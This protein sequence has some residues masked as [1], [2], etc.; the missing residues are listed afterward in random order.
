MYDLLL[1]SLK[2]GASLAAFFLFF[3]LLLSRETF[4]RLNRMLVLGAVVLSFV[5][6]LCVVTVYRELP[7]QPVLPAVPVLD[8]MPAAV[9]AEE[10]AGFAWETLAGALFA[11]G[12]VAA[13]LRTLC[14]LACVL[15]LVRRGR[16][17]RLEG[18]SVLVHS[19]RTGVPFSWWRYIVIPDEDLAHSGRE[20]L[21]H[22][23][24]HL[25]LRHSADLLLMDLAGCLQWFNP[26]FWLLRRELRA[27]HEYEADREVLRSG[28]DPKAYQ[29]LLV[30]KAAGPG[31][32]SVAN[33]FNH[34]KLK[35]RIDMMLRR[36]SSR[37]AGAKALLALPLAALAVGAFAETSYVVPQIEPAAGDTLALSKTEITLRG[38]P[39]EPLV[40][41]DRRVLASARALDSLDAAKIASIT[42]LRDSTA[43]L[44][45]GTQARN[46]VVIV[47]TKPDS[48][49]FRKPEFRGEIGL[50]AFRIDSS[51]QNRSSQIDLRLERD[52]LQTG[53]VQTDNARRVHI[54]QRGTK[55]NPLFLV[56]GVEVSDLKDL[57]PQQIESMEVIKKMTDEVRERGY[58]GVVRITTRRGSDF[59][60]P[61]PE[62]IE[63]EVVRSTQE[64]LRSAQ[65][66]IDAA[67]KVLESA[68]E[69]IP[70]KQWEQA[71]RDLKKAQK[72]LDQT[73][74]QLAEARRKRAEAARSEGRIVWGGEGVATEQEKTV[75]E[76]D[77][78]QGV[79]IYRGEVTLLGA[80]D[81]GLILLNG[82]RATKADV[83][84]IAPKK[85]RS[86]A[87]YS[88][89]EALRKFGEE[90]RD[91]V[92]VI[93]T[94]K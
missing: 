19:A 17:E 14:S 73:R 40:V 68:R 85:I 55:G 27:I 29:M 52:T 32:Y 76:R 47:T 88:G 36:K 12:A 54:R 92:L 9:P 50:V 38:V 1:Y 87:V 91:G 34:S 48:A 8:Q 41:V 72:Q 63:R 57:N 13:L 23:Q 15:R 4:H 3:K 7:V 30:R 59:R 82:K 58:T 79:T 83:E 25:R 65:E 18:G 70:A 33:S 46:G 35:N 2:A 49:S 56:D 78:K 42:V 67:R 75:V 93:R 64:G 22:E 51:Q 11:A 77:G 74:E 26:A 69:Q 10:E 24:A 28:A 43:T 61:D 53:A 66:G 71:Q 62:R 21:L 31:W 86:M 94:R 39:G 84:R 44:L 81:V 89:E 16:R 20:I 6:P 80:P 45:Y 5:L 37:W 60:A 90:G